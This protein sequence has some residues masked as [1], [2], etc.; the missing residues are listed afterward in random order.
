MIR[1]PNVR[2]F[3]TKPVKDTFISNLVFKMVTKA[4]WRYQVPC[5]IEGSCVYVAY[6]HTSNWDTVLGICA[7]YIWDRKIFILVKENYDRPVLRDIMKFCS[8]LPIQRSGG[9]LRSSQEYYRK[10]G[11]SITIAPEGTRKLGR[12]WKKGFHWLA[13]ENDIPIILGY[14]NYDKKIFGW[15]AK[16][17][18]GETPEDTLRTC[19]DVYDETKP[20]GK[21]PRMANPISFESFRMRSNS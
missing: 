1:S 7:S 6:P 9:A 19:R 11:G 14:Y 20:I 17:D 3:L 10:V 15:D 13:K 16:F 21:Y 2:E 5:E 4:G 18:A 12:G 8:M